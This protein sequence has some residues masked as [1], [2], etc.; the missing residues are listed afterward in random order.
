MFAFVYS[1]IA[2]SLVY[3]VGLLL[4]AFSSFSAILSGATTTGWMSLAGLMCI[5]VSIA[6]Y[7]IKEDSEIPSPQIVV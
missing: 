4:I 3:F 6:L 2:I 7:K 1:G 5:G